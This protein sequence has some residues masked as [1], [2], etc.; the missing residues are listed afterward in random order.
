MEN[1]KES[2]LTVLKSNSG[3]AKVVMM[4]LLVAVAG[5]WSW[6]NYKHPKVGTEGGE[7]PA[8]AAETSQLPTPA[9]Q[10]SAYESAQDYAQKNLS[11][12]GIIEGKL[13]RPGLILKFDNRGD[14][15]LS[16]VTVQIIGYNEFYVQDISK[17][18]G[19]EY[20]VDLEVKSFPAKKVTETV[21]YFPTGVLSIGRGIKVYDARF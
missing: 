15:D 13:D 11:F 1:C 2:G 21:L 4:C 5:Y 16:S 9:K 18:Q 6:N 10:E 8:P 12:A 17:A 7:K 20:T 14:R 19:T 3:R